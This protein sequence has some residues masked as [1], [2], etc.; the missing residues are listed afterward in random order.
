MILCFENLIYIVEFDRKIMQRPEIVL[1]DYY[2][3]IKCNRRDIL[4]IFICSIY[5]F[6]NF[7]FYPKIICLLEATLILKFIFHLFLYDKIRKIF[8]NIY[9]LIQFLIH[10]FLTYSLY[11]ILSTHNQIIIFV[12]LG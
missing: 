12:F 11:Y 4:I 10:Q 9:K 5:I 8:A 7:I 1:F 3:A 2:L 6:N